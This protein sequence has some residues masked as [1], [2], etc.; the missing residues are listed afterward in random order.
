[1]EIVMESVNADGLNGFSPVLLPM[2]IAGMGLIFSIIGTWFV[3]IKNDT[4][5]VQNALN[6]GNWSS[7]I[8]TGIAS[9]FLVNMMMPESMEIRGVAFSKMQV[10][11]SILLGLVVGALMSIIT[12]Y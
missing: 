11:Y 10:F 2:V 6:L 8:L 7:I 12:E 5:N 1:Q 4:D 3:R 9:F